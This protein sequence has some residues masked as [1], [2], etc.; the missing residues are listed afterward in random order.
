MDGCIETMRL[1]SREIH[2]AL[3]YYDQK[4]PHN[5]LIPGDKHDNAGKIYRCEIEG[6][7]GRKMMFRELYDY[8]TAHIF[9]DGLI[10]T[11]SSRRD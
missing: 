7:A 9:P 10:Y 4:T 8:Y 6:C 3:H 11:L 5:S 2:L 1:K